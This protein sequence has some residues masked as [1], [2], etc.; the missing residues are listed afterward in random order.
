MGV[1]GRG[2]KV[3]AL[4]TIDPV[5][6]DNPIPPD[7]RRRDSGPR[8]PLDL[9]KVRRNSG[10]WININA[11]PDKIKRAKEGRLGG[12]VGGNDIAGIGGAWNSRI[13]GHAHSHYNA[14]INHADAGDVLLKQD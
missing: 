5:P 13:D 3:G 11:N 7:G 14:N 12:I 4:V 10:N 2:V 6:H 9:E 1:V 8:P